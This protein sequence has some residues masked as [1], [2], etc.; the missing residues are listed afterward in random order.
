MRFQNPSGQLGKQ[1]DGSCASKIRPGNW[2][3]KGTVRALS[4]SVQ[5]TRKARGRPSSSK[6]Q[7]GY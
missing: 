6:F 4:K 1:G 2:E 7:L 3:S 5:A